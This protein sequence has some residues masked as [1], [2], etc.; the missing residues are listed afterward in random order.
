MA[1]TGF[2]YPTTKID[3]QYMAGDLWRV[4]AEDTAYWQIEVVTPLVGY[5]WF[6]TFDFSIPSGKKIDGIEVACKIQPQFAGVAIVKQF[7]LSWNGGTNYV[8]K[9]LANYSTPGGWA[10]W[11]FGGASDAW[12]RTWAIDEFSNTNL[13]MKISGY[14]YGGF[15]QIDYVW[16]KVYYSDADKLSK[17]LG[18]NWADVSTVLG[19][20]K[21]SIAKIS[22]ASVT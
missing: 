21:A 18:A 8:S 4:Q 5:C 16:M 22:G 12:G 10:V 6:T 17:V 9:V 3:G 15:Y 11:T 13:K 1:D 14:T 19:C 7:D 20:P 2:K